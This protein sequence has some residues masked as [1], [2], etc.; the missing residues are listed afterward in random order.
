[1]P[2]SSGAM[3]HVLQISK[4][5]H[6]HSKQVFSGELFHCPSLTVERSVDRG[7][8]KINPSPYLG[9]VVV[10]AALKRPEMGTHLIRLSPLTE[11]MGLLWTRRAGARFCCFQPEIADVV[12][13]N[14]RRFDLG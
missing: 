6:R 9:M 1:M 12:L 7:A 3:P 10:L 2:S 5:G 11:L 8:E 14:R 4:P 13:D